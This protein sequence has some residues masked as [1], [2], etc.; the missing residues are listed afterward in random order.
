MPGY[1]RDT[2]I[3]FGL[4]DLVVCESHRTARHVKSSDGDERAKTRL[5]TGREPAEKLVA[6]LKRSK[7]VLGCDCGAFI[8]HVWGMTSLPH[9][10]MRHL[11]CCN[12]PFRPVHHAVFWILVHDF[13]RNSR[14]ANVEGREPCRAVSHFV[15]VGMV[16][17]GMTVY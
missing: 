2:L 1:L 13:K 9:G 16:E 5:R 7:G 6:L 4:A 10:R 3:R 15:C 11:F 14:D 12:V 8:W 17:L